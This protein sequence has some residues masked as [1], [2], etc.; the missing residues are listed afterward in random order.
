MNTYVYVDD[1][2][3][4]MKDPAE[5]FRRLS[6]PEIHNYKLKGV[7]PPEYHLGGNFGRDP[8]GTLWWGSQ[9]YIE[10]ML[11]NYERQFGSMPAKK[12]APMTDSD[13]PELD[14][15][16]LLDEQG[17]SLYMSMV[18]AMQWAVTLG[19]IDIAYATMVMSRFRVEPRIGHMERLKYLYGYLRRHPDAKIRFRTGYPENEKLFT[20]P[21]ADWMHSVYGEREDDSFKGLPEP[22]GKVARITTWV[23][24]GLHHC[25]VTGKASTGL[26]Q[27]VNQ[28]PVDWGAWKQSTVE[29]ATYSSEFVAAR[30]GVDKTIDLQYTLRAMGVPVEEPSWMLGDNHSVVTSSTIPHSTM[31]KRWVALS[32]HRVRCCIAHGLIRFCHVDTKNNVSDILTKALGFVSMWPFVQTLLFWRGDTNQPQPSMIEEVIEII[33]VGDSVAIDI[34]E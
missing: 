8:D 20:T 30:M 2:M 16:D 9:S 3:A 12:N 31:S 5:F 23:D 1:L 21:E 25:R 11:N 7:G 4:V 22:K 15:S 34:G 18:G 6:D 14:T 28:T 17:K 27:F 10:K 29:T 26:L 13:H 32:Y 33:E 19:R 24:S